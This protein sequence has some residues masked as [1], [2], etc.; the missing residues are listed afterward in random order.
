M[1]LAELEIF[2]A[3][4]HAESVTRAALLLGRV[5]SNVTTRLRQLEDDLGV[6]LFRR[7]NKRMTLTPEGHS[8]LDYAE[9]LLALA[10]EARQAVRSGTPTGLLRLGAMEAAAAS[11]LPA[12]LAHYRPHWPQVTVEIQTG[13]TQFLADAVANSRLDCA[14]VAHPASGAPVDDM[15]ALG[16]GLEGQYLFTENLMLVTP[17]GHPTPASAAGLRVRTLAAFAQGCTYRKCALQWLAEQ[18]GD[19]GRWT[20]LDLNSYDAILARVMAG[21]AAAV[22][23]QSMIDMQR[24][25]AG[26]GVTPLRPVHS[27][28][29]RRAGFETPA[30][31]EFARVLGVATPDRHPAASP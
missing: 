6:T 5:Q 18:G 17:P 30:L 10:E 15:H 19:P 13:T 26:A 22:L 14:I 31:C 16:T 24:V 4:A 20:L 27:Y 12:P 11:R 29:I 28:L 7:D 21:T 9:R 2:R 1:E 8:M 25:P 23:P 3:V